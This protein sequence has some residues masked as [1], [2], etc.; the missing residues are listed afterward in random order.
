MDIFKGIVILSA[1]EQNSY[2]SL[3]AT[4]WPCRGLESSHGHWGGVRERP[5]FDLKR[6]FAAQMAARDRDRV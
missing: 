2:W 5:A 1:G 6:R 3:K 4:F